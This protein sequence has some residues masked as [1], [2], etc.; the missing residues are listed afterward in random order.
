MEEV[1]K[2]TRSNRKISEISPIT[3]F[4]SRFNERKK[5]R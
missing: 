1:E 3:N 4:R 5:C 2:I